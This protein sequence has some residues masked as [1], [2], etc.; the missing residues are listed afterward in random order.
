M[1]PGREL[2]V[3]EGDRVQRGQL[4]ARLTWQDPELERKRQQATA[5][6]ADRESALWLR[7]A[8]VN[9]TRTLVEGGL[10]ARGSFDKADADLRSARQA[11]AQARRAIE[12][13]SD[14][15]RRL[16]EVRAPVD[17]RVLS[18]RVHVIHGS[19]STAALRLLYR[20]TTPLPRASGR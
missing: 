1:D 3:R 15:A 18:V 17:G 8:A 9:Q 19:E 6:L 5:E 7:E 4:L 10:A 11:V 20:K 13:L 14:E 16:R 12:Q 2:L